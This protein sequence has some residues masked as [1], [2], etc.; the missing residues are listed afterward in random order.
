M[1][2]IDSAHP[3]N[4]SDQRK[5]ASI[6]VVDPSPLSLI[7]LA[8]VL[9]YQGYGC[10]CAR[11]ADAA[12]EA[13]DMGPQDLVV[14]DVAD[15]AG[16]ALETL[17]QMRSR[18]DCR[19]LPAVLIAESR[20][21]GLEKKA[22]AMEQ[23]TRCLFKPIDPNSLIAVVHQVLYMPSLVRAH[24]RKGSKPSRPGWVTL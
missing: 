5:Q 8:G 6:V 12:V 22:E 13:L 15:D 17:D 4:H 9:D 10:I 11:T 20:W 14:W 21:A 16:L 23:A 3:D 19:D 2:K 18:D 7:A 1:K 24:R